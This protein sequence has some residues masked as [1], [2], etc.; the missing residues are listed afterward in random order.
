MTGSTLRVVA[1]GAPQKTYIHA[2]DDNKKPKLVVCMLVF[3][4][5]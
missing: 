1:I 2:V 3:K 5:S 4:D